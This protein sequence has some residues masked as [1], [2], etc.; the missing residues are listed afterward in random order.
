MQ[1]NPTTG[2]TPGTTPRGTLPAGQQG[3][4]AKERKRAIRLDEQVSIE[5]GRSAGSR[6]AC[7]TSVA[8]GRVT[9]KVV[10]PSVDSAR[11]VP[12]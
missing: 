4:D 11:T 2:S 9:V 3:H 12:P 8:L 1:T 7:A 5:A 6:Q 10:R